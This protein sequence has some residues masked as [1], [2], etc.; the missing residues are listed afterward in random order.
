MANQKYYTTEERWAFMPEGK[1]NRFP[2]ISQFAGIVISVRFDDT[3]EGSSPCFHAK[4]GPQEAVFDFDGNVLTGE[5]PAKQAKYVFV[6][7][8]MRRFDLTVLWDMIR[9]RGEY[10]KVRGLG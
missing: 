10:F 1:G 8:D 2:V 3:R 6:W 7:A 4:F 9:L 5:F